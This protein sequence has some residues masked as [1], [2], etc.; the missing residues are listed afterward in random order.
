[1]ANVIDEE[2]REF[3]SDVPVDRTRALL[4]LLPGLCGGG[5]V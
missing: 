3:L 1:M 4:H 2:V 5:A